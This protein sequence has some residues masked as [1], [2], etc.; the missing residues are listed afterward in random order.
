MREALLDFDLKSAHIRGL[1]RR[2]FKALR[3]SIQLVGRNPYG[4]P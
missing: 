3:L 4:C 2:Q 1:L